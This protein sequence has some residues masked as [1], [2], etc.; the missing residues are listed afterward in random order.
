[1]SNQATNQK[2]ETHNRIKQ[3]HSSIQTFTETYVLY[4]V[5]NNS[6]VF[7]M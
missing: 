4:T 1:M 5:L 2:I 7:Y 3:A 6:L